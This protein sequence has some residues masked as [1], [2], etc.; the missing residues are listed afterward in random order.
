MLVE[1]VLEKLESVK[2][3]PYIVLRDP[4]Q[5]L[6][7][8]EDGLKTFA[9]NNDY[10]T[11]VAATNL[12]FR[13]LLQEAHSDPQKQKVLLIDRTPLGRQRHE[14][15]RHAPPIFYPDLLD[16]VPESAYITLDLQ[17]FLKD[18]T[19]GDPTWPK[20]VNNRQYARLI[21]QNL[22]GVLDAYG[23]LR[24][25]DSSRFTDEDLRKIVA[26]ASLGIGES[27]FISLKPGDYWKIGLLKHEELKELSLLTPDVIKTV[28]QSL[29]KAPKPFCW[30]AQHDPDVVIRGFYLSLIISQHSDNWPLILQ[31]IA[32]DVQFFGDLSAEELTNIAP[33]LIK[34]SPQRANADLDD[35]ENYLDKEALSLLL[36]DQLH[37]DEPQ[38]FVSVIQQENFS[39]LVRSLTLLLAIR[40][41]MSPKPSLEYQKQLY[42]FLFSDQI[43]KTPV[44]VDE[45]TSRAWTL[46]KDAYKNVYEL[47]QIRKNLRTVDRLVK[48]KPT[49]DLNFVTF[50]KYWNEKHIN[51][52][53]YSLSV[54]ERILFTADDLLLPRRKER[55][56]QQFIEILEFVRKRIPE[57]KGKEE[58]LINDLNIRFQEVVKRDY[59]SWTEGSEEVVLTS[60]FISR[61]LKPHWDPQTENAVIFIFDGMRYDI[62][63]EFLRPQLLEFMEVVEELRGCSLIPSE[64]KISR[65]AIS[66]GGFPDSFRPN[67]AEN[68]LLE[69][70]VARE[71]AFSPKIEKVDPTDLGIG[72]T[73]RYSADS[74][75]LE[76]YIFE[77]CDKGLHNIRMK[78]VDGKMVPARPLA[79]IYEEFRR[80]IER[81]VM[82]I[83]RNLAPGTKV[84]VTADHGFGPVGR[85]EI[86]FKKDDLSDPG[87]CHYL[88]CALPQPLSQTHLPPHIQSNIIEFSPKILRLPVEERYIEK[89]TRNEVVKKRESIVFPK[90]GYAFSRPGKY[91]KPDAYSHGGISLQELLIPMA[92]LKVKS[93]EREPVSVEF[94]AAPTEIYEGEEITFRVQFRHSGD[95]SFAG[96]DLRIDLDARESD[97]PDTTPL[98]PR[99]IF[100]SPWS[101]HTVDFRFTPTTIE[102]D[103]EERNQ[104]S[105]NRLFTL[106]YSYHDGRK[107]VR[108]VLIHKFVVNLNSGRIVRRVGSLGNILGLTPKG[109]QRTME[110]K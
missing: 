54:V 44:F 40:D 80:F 38:G 62:W 68:S 34:E 52:L 58:K 64:T 99:V 3:E 102:I 46:L 20:E 39:T 108:N 70:S 59:P 86:W 101:Q 18:Q 22:E 48:V 53:E 82:A 27:A 75:K 67:D 6:S 45:R 47:L 69:A 9:D 107:K 23:N 92:V 36:I 28:K 29:T 24:R 110:F 2:N 72:Q 106:T 42:N 1:W 71:F 91:F 17:E 77:F 66:A 84:F 43:E 21:A 15:G 26:F 57:I 78:E 31:S 61:L 56:P 103:D 105:V 81:D 90:V 104:G 41:L 98:R 60:Q 7:P 74:G 63:D 33:S 89:R 16:E 25:A 10:I 19:N 95:S 8:T 30:F 35:A 49:D 12:V 76:M 109:T 13:E 51:R 55:L 87:D 93:T 79:D 97:N 73:V 32:P 37:I 14:Q 4:L 83:M 5:L 96:E 85:D 100:L 88:H 94:I 11:I 65:N 50:W